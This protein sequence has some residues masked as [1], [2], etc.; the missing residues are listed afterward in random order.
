MTA[1]SCKTWMRNEFRWFVTL[2]RFLPS[3]PHCAMMM[4][5]RWTPLPATFRMFKT[6][7][8]LSSLKAARA[9]VTSIR[10]L[11]PFSFNTV[12][13]LA[14]SRRRK[15]TDHCSSKSKSTLCKRFFLHSTW[16]MERRL[17]SALMRCWECAQTRTR[18]SS[19]I[20]NTAKA[21]SF[22][23]G[24]CWLQSRKSCDT[25]WTWTMIRGGVR[26]SIFAFVS[27]A[28]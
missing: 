10:L 20:S 9:I 7:K 1:A 8:V 28:F 13:S 19:P 12:L 26:H 4:A 25:G 17:S 3:L 11:M 18:L 22:I 6:R 27:F 2:A 21:R 14:L 24:S 5:M 23:C 16:R 15:F